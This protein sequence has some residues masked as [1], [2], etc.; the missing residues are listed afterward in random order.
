MKRRLPSLNALAAFEAGARLGRMT[1][2]AEEL[3]VTHGA[4]SRQVKALEERLGIRLFEGRRNRLALTAAGRT[5]LPGLTD[6]FDCIERVV[7]AVADE[8]EGPLDVS[9]LGTFT[10]RWLIPRLHRFH[11]VHPGIDV[12]LSADDRPVDFR[13]A[14]FDVAIRVGP[15]PWPTDAVA[16]ALFAEEVGPVC[17]P[18]LVTGREPARLE[19]LAAWPKLHTFTRRDAWADWAAS[20]GWHD[21]SL[22]GRSF[23]HFYF[24][25]EAATAGLGI[26]I[27]PLPLVEDDLK[28]GR[29][30]A[31]LGFIPAARAMSR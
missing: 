10:M 9:V 24:V 16:T 2:A 15:G 7:R 1:L 4:I 26:A 27:A 20:V 21:A 13:R 22:D 12:R 5:L 17:A 18:A 31:P 8:A 3:G 25:L 14:S 23:E 28:A 6:G 11:H 19:D 30:I 29:L